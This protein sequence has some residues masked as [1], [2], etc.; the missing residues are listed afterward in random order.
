MSGLPTTQRARA[1]MLVF[2]YHKVGTTLFLK[3][4]TSVAEALGLSL[5]N[6]Y[7]MVLDLDHAPDIVLLPHS[8]LGFELSRPF[9]A[10]RV[11]RDPRDIWVSSY[12]YHLLGYEAWCTNA[13]FNPAPPIG[14]PRVD[15]SV[16]HRPERWKRTYLTG[17]G[18]RSYQQNLLE[19]ERNEGLRFELERYTAWT[20][21]A[22][23]AW[24][25]NNPAVLEVKLEDIAQEFDA[26]MRAI[27]HH[28][29]LTEAECAV[30]LKLAA[31]QDI[32]RMADR[33]IVTNQHIHSRAISKWRSVLSADQVADFERRHG[34]LIDSLGYTLATPPRTATPQPAHITDQRGLPDRAAKDRVRALVCEGFRWRSEMEPVRQMLIDL[35]PVVDRQELARQAALAARDRTVCVTFIS[36]AYL[37]IGMAWLDAVQRLTLEN[38]LVIAGDDPTRAAVAGRGVACVRAE[39]PAGH[40]DPA[41]LSASG[42]TWTGLALATLQFPIVRFLLAQGFDVVLSHADAIWLQDPLPYCRGLA[43]I[44]F[45][46]ACYFPATIA[47]LWGFAA[48]GGFVY[49]RAGSGTIDFL[50]LCVHE[51][52]QVQDD[53]IALNLALLEADTAWSRQ[54]PGPG[55]SAWQPSATPADL[56]AWFAMMAR[57]PLRGRTQRYGLDLLALPHHQFWRHNCVAASRAEMVVCH[58]NSPKNEQRKLKIFDALGIQTVTYPD[59]PVTAGGLAERAGPVYGQP[60]AQTVGRESEAHCATQAKPPVSRPARQRRS[61]K[62]PRSS[63][64]ASASRT[65]PTTS[66]R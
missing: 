13:D 50:D 31:R 30:A 18:G 43:D 7:G 11:V 65:P 47:Q 63:A 27:F 49:C 38:V 34:D 54:E 45:Q 36:Q 64:A 9:R 41:Y 6:Q 44:A 35:A 20:L 8:L 48:C 37:R 62:K 14:Y 12:L 39:L 16:R 21:E 46:R 53:Q 56:Q 5:S 61:A 2:T 23:R 40:G 3:V 1:Q 17:L 28:L 15:F 26:C 22:M 66:G 24:R 58:P 55:A 52:R 25:L 33:D 32:A 60:A 51:C 59:P 42:F 57:Y 10:I 29:G 19:R 4:M